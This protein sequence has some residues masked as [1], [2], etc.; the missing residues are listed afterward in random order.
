MCALSIL[1]C[2]RHRSFAYLYIWA[3]GPIFSGFFTFL[4]DTI[5]IVG[6]Q[7]CGNVPEIFHHSARPFMR[8]N[9]G[10]ATDGATIK[11][12]QS[13]TC[14]HTCAGAKRTP[15]HKGVFFFRPRGRAIRFSKISFDFCSRGLNHLILYLKRP[16]RTS[17]PK[18]K[19]CL[20]AFYII[21]LPILRPDSF[22]LKYLIL[23]PCYPFLYKIRWLRHREQKSDKFVKNR[24]AEGGA[25]R[26]ESIIIGQ[27]V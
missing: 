22:L 13:C 17:A 18:I 11:F 27:L 26:L 19:H 15:V 3:I 9:L 4:H 14:M 16:R 12:R 8:L 10:N 6:A 5:V 21:K 2:W 1:G 20:D 24:I 25:L 7:T 23:L